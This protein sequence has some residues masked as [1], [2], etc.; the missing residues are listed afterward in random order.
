MPP[1]RKLLSN[2]TMPMRRDA[3]SVVIPV[4][5]GEATIRRAVESIL[6]QTLAPNEI[7]VVDDGSTDATT[8]ILR[9][10][11][12]DRLQLVQ[13]LHQG[14]AAAANA[15]TAAAKSEFIARMDADDFSYPARLE[16]QLALLKNQQLDLVGCHV[17]IVDTSGNEASTLRRYEKWINNETPTH[18]T[19]FALRFVELPIVNPTILARRE[20]F[21]LGFLQ[22]EFP[23]DYDL[24][25]RAANAGM[26]FG[27]VD[28]VLFDWT[29]H[30]Q[31]LT[32]NDS[33]FSSSAF[34][35]CRQTH[36][37]GGPLSSVKQ[38]DLWGVGKTGKPWLRWLQS[39][40]IQVRRAYDIDPRKV[41]QT[42]HGVKVRDPRDL[43]YDGTP[44]IVAVGADNARSTIWP[45]L[46]KSGFTPGT[47][48][49]FMA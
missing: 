34:M 26:R 42:I 16:H 15:G 6:D 36:L 29:D 30:P 31:R 28:K 35:A 41:D 32:R 45:Q 46:V 4:F 18:E 37:L 19:I 17:R 11:K 23:E 47:D 38:I 39:N 49:W 14:V 2:E 27:K 1:I 48:V 20:Y 40:R 13:Q 12:S 3:I 8:Q 22:N 44:M 33:R 21:E 43:I 9:S 10:I 5:N 24:M 25:L 7:I